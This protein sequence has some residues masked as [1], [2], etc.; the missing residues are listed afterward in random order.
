MAT[1]TTLGAARTAAVALAIVVGGCLVPAAYPG[2]ADALA[3]LGASA[4]DPST[5]DPTIDD[6]G[7]DT[8]TPTPQ[9]SDKPQPDDTATPEPEP[10]EPPE[11]KPETPDVEETGDPAEPPLVEEP[12]ADGTPEELPAAPP[13]LVSSDSSWAS[14]SIAIGALLVSGILLAVFARPGRRDSPAPEPA[15]ARL[16]AVASVDSADTLA[17]MVVAGEAMTDSGYPV[18]LVRTSLEDIAAVNGKAGTEVLVFPTALMVSMEDGRKV[19]TKAVSS[20]QSP[21]LLF[22]IERLDTAVNEARAGTVRPATS[23]ARILA[24]RRLP[25]PFGVW[26][27]ILGYVVLSLGLSVLL[28]ASWLGVA[29][30][31]ALGALV[32]V[33]LLLGRRIGSQYQAI[34]TVGA[35]FLVSLVVLL[36]VRADLD[37]GVFPSLVAPLVIL[38]PGALLTTAVIELSTGQIM[39]GSARLA[40]GAMQLVLLAFGIVAAGA[41]VGVP[42]IQ[43]DAAEQPLGPAAPWIGVALFG[44][45]IVIYQCARPSALGW[46]LLVL[47]VAYGAQVLG[48]I[49]FGGVLS[50]FIGA[51]AMTPVALVVA[52]QRS[53]P[54]A[55]VSFLPAFWLLV[56]GALGLVGVTNIL[57]GDEGGVGTLVTTAATMVAIAL[58][59][60]LGLG[61]STWISGASRLGREPGS[62]ASTPGR[63]S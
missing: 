33:L 31:A 19:E 18:N 1:L 34:V 7:P 53:G 44:A 51:F 6:T 57:D 37:P 60:L 48:D 17:L 16:P 5:A 38:L 61:L 13:A 28:G 22:Q 12:P 50:A 46:I 40:A 24:V 26:Q 2:A 3:P 58:G 39:A 45:G 30:A 55:I 15:T 32:G 21:L 36:V 47:Y 25:L 29:L 63:A 52:R 42:G 4:A 27:R 56:P 10:T 54:P 11:P 62:P 49:L 43:L 59:V 14:V 35:A 41:L 8:P 20:G 9:P 23:R